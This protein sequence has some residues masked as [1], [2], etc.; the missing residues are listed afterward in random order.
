MTRGITLY[1]PTSPLKAGSCEG[2][3]SLVNIKMK[4]LCDLNRGKR[5]KQRV[6]ADCSV[7]CQENHIRI[8]A[9]N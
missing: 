3:N 5:K 9:I 1:F 6:T 7:I 2:K 4:H 8:S